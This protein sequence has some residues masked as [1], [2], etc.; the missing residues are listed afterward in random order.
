MFKNLFKPKETQLTPTTPDQEILKAIQ[1]HVDMIMPLAKILHDRGYM[2]NLHE[3]GF[4]SNNM[5]L[6]GYMD[7]PEIKATAEKLVKL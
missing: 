2:V 5:K 6:P 4:Y 7:D 1:E 3:D